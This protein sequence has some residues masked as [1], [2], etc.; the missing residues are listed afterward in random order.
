MNAGQGTQLNREEKSRTEY[1]ARNTTVAMSARIIAIL[2]GFCTRVVFTHTLSEEYVGIN[3]LF[4]DILNV[5]AL[6]ELGIGTAI[7][8]ALYKPIAEKDIEKQKSLMRLYKQFYRVVALI[9]LAAG[10]LVIPFMDLLIKNETQVENLTFLYLLYLANSVISYLLVYKRTLI[11]AYQLSYIGVLYQTAFLVIQNVVQMLVL[12]TTQNFTL[13][14]TILIGCTLLNNLCVSQKANRMYP[15]LKEKQVQPLEKEEKQGIY[16]NIR[17]M[18]M[19]KVGNVVVN[20]TDNLLLSSLVGIV[21]VGMY[22]NYY[23]VIGSVRQVLNQA[24]QGITASV[25]NLGVEESRERVQRIFETAFFIGQWMFGFAVICLFELLTPFVELSFGY[26]YIFDEGITFVL[27]LNFYFTGMRQ[28]TLVFRDSLGLFW[29]DRYKSLVEAL[30]NLAVSIVLGLRFGV[31]G[32]FIGTLCSTLLTSLWVEPYVLY[33]YRLKTPVYQYFLKYGKYVV[34]TAIAWGMTHVLCGLVTGS[35]IVLCMVRLG[36]C[37]I[38]PNL[39]FLLAYARGKEFRFVLEKIKQMLWNRRNRAK[40]EEGKNTIAFSKEEEGLF[41]L[42]RQ[43][44]RLENREEDTVLEFSKQEWG[45][46]VRVAEK[47][48]VLSLLYTELCEKQKLPECWKH[49]VETVATQVAMQQYRLLFTSKYLLNVLEKAGITAVVLK[50]VTVGTLYPVPELRKS[51]DVDVLLLYPEDL[52]KV[53]AILKQ[54]GFSADEKQMALH[55]VCFSLGK[56]MELELHTMLAEPFDNEKTNILLK[57]ILQELKGTTERWNVMGVELPVLPGAYYAFELLLHM[58]Q[59][60]LRSGFGLKLLC[61]WVLYWQNELSEEEKAVYLELTERTGVKGFSDMITMLCVRFLGL[62]EA[63][64][65]WMHCPKDYSVEEFM[66]EILDA[67]EFGKSSKDRMVV[68]RG[69]GITDFVREFHHQ[70]RLNFPKASKC[71]LTWPV[72]WGVTLFRFLKN[73]RALR[74]TSARKI[75]GEA[76]RRSRMMKRIHLFR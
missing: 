17:A 12:V 34:V 57:K 3:G 19:H 50:G 52:E 31:I 13:F 42:L 1:S 35:A 64:I 47:H 60:F 29:Y 30:I 54:C 7:T 61:D 36:I 27:C 10:L 65:H 63:K 51:G 75:L 16:Q 21:S 53:T 73:N 24:F 6:S 59:H 39:L 25:G 37:V 70:M 74:N 71:F 5:L 22:S 44:L 11:E 18:L 43:S 69:T 76:A 49:K 45:S 9:V 14:L 20:N 2:L 62:E 40:A 26:Q 56:G 4:T 38:V 8:Y 55:H 66:R 33:K 48:A 46:L 23:L 41:C 58:L 32:I 68:L 28:A 67:E 72:L 15:F